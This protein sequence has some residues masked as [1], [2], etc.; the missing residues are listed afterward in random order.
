MKLRIVFVL[1]LLLVL[2]SGTKI[3]GASGEHDFAKWET[4]VAAF[5][6]QDRETP[7][8][9]RAILF[10]GSSTIALENAGR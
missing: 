8:P 3:N 9:Q 10:T 2:C 1:A 4:A 5:E 6:Q 7:P